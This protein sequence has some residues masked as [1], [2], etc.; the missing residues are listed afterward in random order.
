MDKEIL[1]FIC[2]YTDN[3]EI[4][5]KNRDIKKDFFFVTCAS[6]NSLTLSWKQFVF[7][8]RV[9]TKTDIYYV[10]HDKLIET[11]N[12]YYNKC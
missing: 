10:I 2:K 8:H 1:V 7:L 9:V 3:L 11:Y 4:S 6:W 12:M 5:W